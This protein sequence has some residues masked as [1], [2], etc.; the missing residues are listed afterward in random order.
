MKIAIIG[1]GSVGS[2]LAKTFSKAGHEIRLGVKNPSEEKYQ[3][4][5]EQIAGSVSLHTVETSVEGVDLAILATPWNVVP[6]VARQ[7]EKTEGLIV[8]DATNPLKPDFSDLDHADGKSGAE[9]VQALLPN[10][11]VLKSFNTTGAENMAHPDFTNGNTLMLVAGDDPTAKDKLLN[12]IDQCGFDAVDAGSLAAAKRLEH[13]AMVW[14]HLAFNSKL[15]R[16]FAF[17]ALTRE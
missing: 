16:R 17:A 10:A 15:G 5:A 14:I 4:I 1:V 12:L 3:K 2:A 9:Q 6:D 7:L 13:L 8:V 11:I